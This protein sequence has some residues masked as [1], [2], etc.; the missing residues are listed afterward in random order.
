MAIGF[1]FYKKHGVRQ[2]KSKSQRQPLTIRPISNSHLS[3]LIFTGRLIFSPVIKVVFRF[4][5]KTIVF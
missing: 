5:G 2:I 1:G 4:P 3:S